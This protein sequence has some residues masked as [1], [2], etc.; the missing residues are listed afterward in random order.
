M[1]NSPA[2]DVYER[3]DFKGVNDI[4]EINDPENLI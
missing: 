4:G 1:L 3:N 2:E